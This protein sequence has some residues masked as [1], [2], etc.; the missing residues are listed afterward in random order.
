[1]NCQLRFAQSG[2]IGLDLSIQLSA[3]SCTKV[4]MKT[5]VPRL[6]EVPHIGSEGNSSVNRSLLPGHNAA[7]EISYYDF[8]GKRET[9]MI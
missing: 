1:M 9:Y 4:V 2:V 7:P 5:W 8:E 6:A 3:E